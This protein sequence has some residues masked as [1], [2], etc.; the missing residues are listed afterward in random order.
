M[1]APVPETDMPRTGPLLATILL[2]GCLP[3]TSAV[4]ALSGLAG[5]GGAWYALARL[6]N[7]ME[8]Q[9]I[10]QFPEVVD[11]IV[12]LSGAGLPP[13]EA[14]SSVAEDAQKPVQPILRE[15]TD[16]LLAMRTPR[17]AWFHSAS[18]SPSSRCSLPSFACNAAPGAA[19][20]RPSRTWRRR[21]ASGARWH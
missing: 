21:S 3:P 16:A 9:F 19:F 4:Q 2:A 10:Q 7:K 8:S 14:L 15:V 12:R 11:Q 5:A 6:Q 20:R 17:S 13:L 18:G 1:S